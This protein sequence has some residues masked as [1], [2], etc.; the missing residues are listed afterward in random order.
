MA[1][2]TETSR[3]SCLILSRSFSALRVAL[4]NSSTQL[5]EFIT[6]RRGRPHLH[7]ERLED[8]V[9]AMSNSCVKRRCMRRL[10][11]QVAANRYYRYSSARPTTV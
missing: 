10:A 3:G 9:E 5:L 6:S 7:A 2:A 11:K 1:N 4:N 8:F